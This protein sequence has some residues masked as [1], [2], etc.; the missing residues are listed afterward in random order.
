VFH[1]EQGQDQHGPAL[2]DS[3]AGGHSTSPD[4]NVTLEDIA[5]DGD[6]VGVRGEMRT[7][8][9]G[10]E[11]LGADAT[12]N[13][14]KWNGIAMCKIKDGRIA[15]RWFNSD[16]LSAVTCPSTPRPCAAPRP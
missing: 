12:G 1:G 14:L 5:A 2:K 6:Y 8:H 3:I 7:H 11:F 9:A 15:E 16:S 4:L 10:G 13:E